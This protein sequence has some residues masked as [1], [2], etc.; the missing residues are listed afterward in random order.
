M[1]RTATDQLAP[2]WD[3]RLYAG[4]RVEAVPAER[5]AAL[6]RAVGALGVEAEYFLATV[7]AFLAPAP[8][9]ARTREA[10]EVFLWQLE[11]SAARL[12][13]AA[14]TFELATQ[15]FLAALDESDPELRA[16][17]GTQAAGAEP[18]W[19]EPADQLGELSALDL[20]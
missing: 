12:R 9:A 3:Q 17:A 10:G 1:Q 14:E 4:V 7:R 20:H 19:L 6:V 8:R 16:G 5:R 15:A 2:H 11:T 13:P 18:W